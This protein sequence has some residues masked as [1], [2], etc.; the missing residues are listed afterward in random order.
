VPCLQGELDYAKLKGDTG[1]LVY[2]AGFVYLF[3]WL[4]QLTGGSVEA[5]Q[6]GPA[7]WWSSNGGVLVIV[8][9]LV[10]VVRVAVVVMCFDAVG[11]GAANMV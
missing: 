1:P 2:P 7:V 6:V 8:V 3:S 4:Q 9:V 5:G 11:G 10:A